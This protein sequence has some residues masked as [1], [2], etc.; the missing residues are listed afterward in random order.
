MG[1][2]CGS[3]LVQAATV[4]KP[5]LQ[6]TEPKSGKSVS[7]S[8]FTVTGKATVAKGI[9]ISNVL[10]SLNYADYAPATTTDG[11]SNW[12][13]A[14]TLT[15][16]SNFISAYALDNDG[17][18]SVTNKV[19][20]FYI[21]SAPLTVETNGGHAIITPKY[22][23][24]SLEIG[25]RYTITAKGTDGFS[26]LDWTGG[27]S[28]PYSIL[29]NKATVAFTMESNLVLVANMVDTE[30][31]YLKITNW[32][33][34]FVASNE[35]FTVMGRATD[36]VA[37]ASVNYSL[38]GS[39]NLQA[40]LNGAS[41]SAPLTLSL[42]SNIFTVYAVD[43]N[44]NSSLTNKIY[45]LRQ[46]A[47]TN[48]EIVSNFVSYPAAQLAFDGNNYLVAYQAYSSS[49][50]S[51]AMG[52]FIS[53]SGNIVGV[54]LTLNPGGQNSPPYLDFDGTNYLVAWADYS[55]IA[56]GVPLRGVF[57]S[58]EGAVGSVMT[59]SQSSSVSDFGSIAYGGGAY[60]LTWADD[61]ST[62]DSIYG[63]FIQT[64]SGFNESGDF[65][66]S[67]NGFQSDAGGVSAAYDG[68]TNFLVVWY[69]ASGKTSIQGC[70][71]NPSGFASSPFVI[72]TNTLATEL[73]TV[74][75]T[76]DG[77]K[78]LVLFST[79]AKTATT[80]DYH[81]LG[82][83]VGTDGTVMTNQITVT[84][85]NGP[86][87]GPSAD[88]DGVNY[89]VSWNQGFNPSTINKSTTTYGEFFDS[90][91]QPASTTF[92][93]FSTRPNAEI[94]LWAPVRWDGT[95]FVV[96]GGFGRMTT[97]SYE[98]TNSVIYGEFIQP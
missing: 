94:P 26:L 88:F 57:V 20:F 82:R 77:T 15:P 59:L 43:P 38:N 27:T 64:N 29:T 83:F 28:S 17:T 70:L 25:K 78:Y 69:A 33:S 2:L 63:A 85:V 4:V 55:S 72:Y 62:P 12:T 75:V 66:I 60:L 5:T 58:P 79:S 96:V 74:S 53:P 34:K 30:K 32:T 37:V 31:P 47:V 48:F 21:L 24:A 80:S 18:F 13:A 9:G 45:I 97:N 56:S 40:T 71:V 54:R 87:I 68:Q 93:L 11:W 14:V 6:I 36:N 50:N 86:Q 90:E 35:M 44:G 67:S 49:S 19:K 51:T 46:P 73:S 23:N 98:F 16:G 81:V 76:F 65:L 1:M 8:V 39:T 92:P 10:Y 7:N 91:G 41:W 3:T 84:S 89:L 42:G 22:N 52:Q 61:R 95:K